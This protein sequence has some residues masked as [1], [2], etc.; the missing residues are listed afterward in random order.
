MR[1]GLPCMAFFADS[2]PL[3]VSDSKGFQQ[4]QRL[5]GSTLQKSNSPNGQWLKSPITQ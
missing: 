3:F 1:R 2:G 4:T 5:N